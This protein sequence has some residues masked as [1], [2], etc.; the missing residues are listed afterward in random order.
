MSHALSAAIEAGM[1]LLLVTTPLVFGC[2]HEFSY[3]A[4]Q[5]GIFGLVV[6]WVGQSLA[7][8]KPQ[9]RSA[10]GRGASR[11]SRSARISKLRHPIVYL[12]AFLALVIA[13]LVPLPRGAVGWLSPN[14]VAVDERFRQESLSVVAVSRANSFELS[15]RSPLASTPTRGPEWLPLSVNPY[16]THNELLKAIAYASAF[17]LVSGCLRSPACARRMSYCIIVIGAGVACLGLY[18][19]FAWGKKI[20][21][22]WE[23]RF[24]SV[25]FGP[26]VNRNHFAGYMAMVL[27]LAFSQFFVYLIPS[28]PHGRRSGSP[29]LGRE[30]RGSVGLGALTAGLCLIAAVVMVAALF[31]SAS[32]GGVMAFLAG[33]GVFVATVLAKR[34]G[35]KALV[36]STLVVSAFVLVGLAIGGAELLLRFDHTVMS[37]DQAGSRPS[38][39]LHTIRIWLDFPVFGVGLGCFRYMFPLYKAAYIGDLDFLRSH[40]DYLQALSDVGVLGLL[41]VLAFLA[42]ILVPALRAI[43]DA[44][45]TRQTWALVGAVAGCAA[46]LAHSLVDFNLQIPANAF[47]FVVILGLIWNLTR[48]VREEALAVPPIR[49]MPVG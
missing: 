2:V 24:G 1:V 27:P 25:P 20:Y 43:A 18:Q 6:L 38:L 34:S 31:A 11:H 13:Q 29:G 19:H 26:Y 48:C 14:R 42:S 46:M 47:L 32:R 30:S 9:G 16:V 7:R 44:D 49:S 45:L 17:L 41:L 22:F 3:T 36:V 28:W 39:W 4:M 21:G 35:L 37:P 33:A 5:V 23:S 8:R 10:L 15:S 12:C 40:C